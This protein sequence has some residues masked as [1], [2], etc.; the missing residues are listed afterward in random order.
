M[1]SSIVKQ[2]HAAEE[3]FTR[4]Q[5]SNPD[6][7]TIFVTSARGLRAVDAVAQALTQSIRA[8]GSLVRSLSPS[9]NAAGEAASLTVEELS[10]LQRARVAVGAAHG[11]SV[12]AADALLDHPRLLMLVAACDATVVVAKRGRTTRSDLTELRRTVVEVGGL[13]TAAV[14]IA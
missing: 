8:T 10:N 5:L 12:I 14:L 9:E 3:L 1:V 7:R 2:Q 6:A 11:Y 13:L 4:L